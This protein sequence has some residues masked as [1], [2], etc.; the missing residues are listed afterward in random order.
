MNK[1]LKIIISIL[2]AWVISYFL[3]KRVDFPSLNEI[4]KSGYNALTFSFIAFFFIKLINTLR[5]SRL[6][7][8]ESSIKLYSLLSYSNLM[9]SIVPFRIGELSYIHGLEKYFNKKYREGT[10]KLIFLR[11][12]DY[13][14]VCILFLL[15]SIHVYHTFGSGII[16]LVSLFFIVSLIL[17]LGFIYLITLNKTSFRGRLRKVVN[18]I[19]IGINNIRKMPKKILISVVLLSL[20]YWILRLVFGYIVLILLGINV[21]IFVVAF[22]SFFLLLGGI[23]PIRPI[24]GFGLFEGGWTYFLVLMGYNYEKTLS[25]I[26]QYHL[27]LLIPSIVFGIMGYCYMKLYKKY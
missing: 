15:S 14:V 19:H 16:G 21:S 8:I 13:I 26:F 22:I 25:L 12:I 10:S 27:I 7:E 4:L 17:F 9:L 2:L 24:L 11:F 1:S 3:F 6:Y 5:Y 20:I 23:T 18:V